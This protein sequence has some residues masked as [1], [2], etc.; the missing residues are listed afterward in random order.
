MPEFSVDEI[1]NQLNT[2]MLEHLKEINMTPFSVFEISGRAMLYISM[3]YK[4]YGWDDKGFEMIRDMAKTVVVP[5]LVVNE[6][7]TK[8]G[9]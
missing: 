7:P 1:K 4:H 5:G 6:D 9:N 8:K 3:L 2:A